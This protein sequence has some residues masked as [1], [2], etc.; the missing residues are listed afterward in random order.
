MALSDVKVRAAKL[1]AKTYK[2]TH[3]SEDM[4]LVIH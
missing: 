4:V 3:S 2:R 1:E